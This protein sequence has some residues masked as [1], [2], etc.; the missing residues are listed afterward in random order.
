[1]PHLSGQ[2]PGC[3]MKLHKE[4]PESEKEYPQAVCLD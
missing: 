3:D 1:M 2:D 4:N